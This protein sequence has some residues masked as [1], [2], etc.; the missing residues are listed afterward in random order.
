MTSPPSDKPLLTSLP[1]GIAAAAAV[2]PARLAAILTENGPLPIRHITQH[3]L[4]D[5]QGFAQLS[6]SK[7]RR[8]IMAALENQTTPRFE[9]IG[10]GQWAVCNLDGSVHNPNNVPLNSKHKLRPKAPGLLS[11]RRESITTGRDP[12]ATAVPFNPGAGSLAILSSDSDDE[13]GLLLNEDAIVSDSDD[14]EMEV[15]AAMAPRM[16]TGRFRSPASRRHSS[17][18]RVGKPGFRLRVASFGSP[19]VGPDKH[20]FDL[21]SGASTPSGFLLD[22]AALPGRS[23]RGSFSLVRESGRQSFVR[24][25]LSPLTQAHFHSLNDLLHG[26]GEEGTDEEDWASVGADRLRNARAVKL[27]SPATALVSP[28][29]SSPRGSRQGFSPQIVVGGVAPG[30]ERPGR[31]WEEREQDAAAALVDLGG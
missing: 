12:H 7:Q 26:D 8:L 29:G 25:T 4:R 6:L 11:A 10:W 19:E 22:A 23:Q 28:P 1:M 3:L 18:S 31:K 21:D 24:S 20:M 17:S 5:I 2:T 13:S 15:P 9:K 14:D 27:E 30:T 16:L